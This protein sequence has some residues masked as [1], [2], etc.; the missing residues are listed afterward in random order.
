MTLSQLLFTFEGRIERRAYWF[1]VVLL[2][3]AGL[4]ASI[5]DRLLFGHPNSLVSAAVAIVSFV[6][7]LAVSVKRWH[8]RDKSGWWVLVIFVPLVGWLWALIENGLLRGTP[9][10]NRFGPDPTPLS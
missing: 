10:P 8:D 3:A 2:F 1:A 7:S 5:L 6:A 9:G 4:V